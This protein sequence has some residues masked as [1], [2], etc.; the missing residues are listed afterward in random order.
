[1]PRD[2]TSTRT[3]DAISSHDVHRIQTYHWHAYFCTRT[4]ILHV[5]RSADIPLESLWAGKLGRALWWRQAISSF[6]ASTYTV[7]TDGSILFL[8]ILWILKFGGV[9][10]TM[11]KALMRAH[12]LTASVIE[13]QTDYKEQ[14]V[15]KRSAPVKRC[16]FPFQKAIHT[17]FSIRLV[18]I[19][20]WSRQQDEEETVGFDICANRLLYET[21]ALKKWEYNTVPAKTNGSSYC[22]EF[23]WRVSPPLCIQLM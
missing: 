23:A 1:M 9:A 18:S 4:F 8:H 10:D 15:I 13:L 5:D 17:I 20:A 11:H 6:G 12:E 14:T 22:I 2:T 16:T 19:V 3:V 7:R 21:S